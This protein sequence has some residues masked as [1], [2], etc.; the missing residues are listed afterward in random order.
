M[1]DTKQDAPAK[2]EATCTKIF[3][4]VEGMDAPIELWRRPKTGVGFYSTEVSKEGEQRIAKYMAFI[5]EGSVKIY[6]G[7]RNRDTEPK[8]LGILWPRNSKEY[9]PFLSGVM[10]VNGLQFDKDGHIAKGAPKAKANVDG[11][12]AKVLDEL[13]AFQASKSKDSKAAEPAKPVEK[14]AKRAPSFR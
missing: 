11:A 8:L 10:D 7:S 5:N 6:A 13:L 12:D 1:S 2:S 9:G 3:L 14:K 4:Q